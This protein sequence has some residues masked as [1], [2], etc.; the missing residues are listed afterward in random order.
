MVG[1]DEQNCCNLAEL[2]RRQ[3]E[4][5]GPR[6]ALRYKRHGIYHDLTWERYRAD[7]LACAAGLVEAGIRPGDRVGLFSE[8]RL[9]W[10]IADM[11]IMTAAAVNVPPHAPLSARQVHFQLADAGVRWLFLSTREQLE[12][13]SQVISDLPALERIVVFDG[14]FAICNLQF[15]VCNLVDT[16]SGFLQRGRH[17]LP[18]LASELQRRE[19]ALGRD[20]LATIM[21]TSGTTGNPKGVMLTH[22]NLL[23]NVESMLAIASLRPEQIQLSWLPYSHI[24]ARTVDHYRSLMNGSLMALA[25]SAE[26]VVADLEDIQPAYMNSVPR[27]YEKVLT[28][29]SSADPQETGRKLR[30]IFGPRLDWLGSGGAPLPLPVAEAYHAAGVRVMQG[31]GLTESSPVISFNHKLRNKLGTVG[32]PLPGVEVAIAADGEVLTRGLHVMK[33]YW[34]N[35]EATAEAIT[36][37][38]LHTGDL[39]RIDED[40]FLIITGRK[41]ELLVLS[42]G[43]K[44]VPT[45][46]EGLLV[47][48]ECIDQA[49]ICGEG[50]RFLTALIV[51]HWD[52]VRRAVQGSGIRNQ[53]SGIG[54][55]ATEESLATA[56]AVHQL[57]KR[58]IEAALAH[59]ASWEQVKKFVILSRPLTVAAEELTVSLKLRRNVVLS[60]YAA[61]L[62]ALYRD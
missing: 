21:Y 2:L 34:N 54:G 18:R 9:E 12:K 1:S 37:G 13:V 14:Q 11:G 43:K 15:A 58:R 24:Y 61:Q 41:K 53:E 10:L 39:G 55:P 51:P 52:N 56:P 59:V 22:G 30:T 26:T 35:P 6:P 7:T 49:V 31:Y 36:D 29:V 32:P 50:R 17:A 47:A 62:D 25:D 46:L 42:N 23:S 4:R 38:W 45:Q 3:A 20:D 28:A 8:N 33:G 44:V 48:D 60:K 5:L 16:W 57:L 40:G 27:L 19:E